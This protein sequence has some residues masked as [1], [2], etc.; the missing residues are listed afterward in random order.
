MRRI[1]LL[2]LILF[3]SSFCLA[4]TQKEEYKHDYLYSAEYF[5]YLIECANQDKMKMLE[6][7]KNKKEEILFEEDEIDILSEEY[8]PFHLRIEENR[9]LGI[10]KDTY[11]KDDSKTTI[12]INDKFAFIQDVSKTRNKYNSNDYKILAGAE[13]KPFKFINISSGLETNY[14]SLD[15]NPTSKKLY[16]SPSIHFGDRVYIKFHNKMN[17]M[18]YSADHDISL[19]VSPFKSKVLDFGVYSGLTRRQNGSISESINFTTNFYF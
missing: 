14:R 17:V 5:D 3:F 10:Y 1:V 13:F 8:T 18:N 7:E 19:N 11:K 9:G 2:I 6:E 15:Q 4:K 16:F 12:P